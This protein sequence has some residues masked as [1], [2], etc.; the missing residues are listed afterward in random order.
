M[1]VGLTSGPP[2]VNSPNGIPGPHA[3]YPPFLPSAGLTRRLLQ[4]L[5]EDENSHGTLAAWC[6]EGDNRGDAMGLAAVVL[7]LLD[8]GE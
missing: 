1:L 6:V 4:E 5:Q 2:E 7:Q 8:L 3:P